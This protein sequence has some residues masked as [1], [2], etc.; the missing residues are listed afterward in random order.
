MKKMNFV[1]SWRVWTLSI[2]AL[3]VAGALM[4]WWLLLSDLPPVAALPEKLVRPT[5]QI[6]DRNGRLLYEVMDP[7]AGKQIDLSLD[8][9]PQ[10]CMQATIATED[11]RFY[12]HP[13]F[14]PI[15]IARALVQ[16]FRASG[17][18]VSGGSTITQQVARNTLLAPEER[19]VQSVQRKIRE[20]WLA[21]LIERRY[22]KD[23]VLA[24]YLN[25]TYY[26]NFAFGLE[27]AA[28]IFF[29]KPAKQLSQGE[30]ALL[31]GLVQYPTGYNP[32]AAPDVAKNR[33]LTVLRLMQDAGYIDAAQSAAIA[34]EPLRYKSNLFAIQAPHFVMYVQDLVNQQV[35]VDAL[36]A[37]GLTV[38]TT[39][40][41]D[42]QR[43]VEQAVNY[44][45][46]LLNCRIPGECTAA[47]DPKR[48]ADNAA[49][50]VLDSHTG[51]ILAMV[52]SPNYF[53]A[54]I[55]GNLNA[56]LAL[57]Q[58]GSAIKPL[59]YAAA[60]DPAWSARAG[61]LPL[62][63]A[64]IIPDL[65]TTFYV[66]DET[67]AQTP[68]APVNYDRMSHGPVSVRD[69]LANSYNIPAVKVLER[70]GVESL[71][72]I[73]AQS[74][75]PSFNRDFGLALT[76]GGGE[77]RLLELTAAYGMLDDGQRLA[78]RAIRTIR[79]ENGAIGGNTGIP[80]GVGAQVID[81]E[82]AWLMTDILS[83]NIARMPAF[84]GT[85]PLSLPFQAAAKTGTTTDWRDNWT[86]GYS[87]ERV[88]GV[89]VGN[90]DNTPMIDVSG[91]DG[92][93]PIWRDVMVAAH[94]DPPA[95]FPKPAGI[96]DAT[97][98]APTGLLAT[99][100]CPRTRLE[101]FIAGTE[102]TQADNQFVAV[103]ID[104]A[105]GQVATE[106]TPRTQV[107][108]RTYWALPAQYHD[109]AVDEGIALLTPQ[110]AGAIGASVRPYASASVESASVESASVESV[111]VNSAAASS[112]TDHRPPTTD[113]RSLL[114][115]DPASNVA[116]RTWPGLPGENQRIA[117]RG[118]VADGAPWA[119]LRLVARSDTRGDADGAEEI[120]IA[121]AVDA[122]RISGWFALAPGEWRFVLEGERTPGGATEQSGVAFVQIEAYPAE[123]AAQVG[124]P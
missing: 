72:R 28:N 62:T 104:R 121:T 7:N 77:V 98:C 20:A 89:W 35:G 14:D 26:G 34:A 94:E 11:K 113:Y 3:L 67:G 23:E 111:T 90:A 51:E 85:S 44:R 64:S 54:S 13:G 48:R 41:L 71:K 110:M 63:P 68:Y 39:L 4:L 40:D 22:S 95:N 79:D 91:I 16:N 5:T 118:Y 108:E 32:L 122:A 17:D 57:R 69:A 53:D 19:Y 59:T 92:A 106:K 82:T 97:V 52:G 36:R 6:L 70:I 50:V 93:G 87:T 78:P 86:L 15:A 33:Q 37:G 83:D 84:G 119:E 9:V 58:P 30:C 120:V 124:T 73:A 117:V 1:P 76:L 43:K 105:T 107:V 109:W 24:L 99:D 38:T 61:V 123:N 80:T 31:A 88:V 12:Y 8:S 21:F 66:T 55:Q 42:L 75:I 2:A 81:P 96:V 25:Q 56:A 47:T 65:P 74:G 102:P 112:T 116:Y 29:A 103:A 100:A 46:D 101:H 115:T 60:L 27:A 10:A 18:I 49:V 45:L 114:L